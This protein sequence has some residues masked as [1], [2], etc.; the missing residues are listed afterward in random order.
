MPNES[1]SNYRIAYTLTQIP[2]N[3][4]WSSTSVLRSTWIYACPKCIVEQPPYVTELIVNHNNL[5]LF[6][7]SEAVYAQIRL[8]GI[9]NKL[10]ISSDTL[11][12]YLYVKVCAHKARAHQRWGD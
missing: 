2:R 12:G 5:A 11:A 6:H 4:V 1:H 9:F 3:S 10:E 7:D 8:A